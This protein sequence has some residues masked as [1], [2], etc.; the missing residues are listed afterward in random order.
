MVEIASV[1]LDFC[2]YDVYEA[3]EWLVVIELLNEHLNVVRWRR[4][5]TE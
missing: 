2:G 5:E 3:R 4:W 1:I